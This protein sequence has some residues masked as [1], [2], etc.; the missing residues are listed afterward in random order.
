MITSEAV[1]AVAEPAGQLG[2]PHFARTGVSARVLSLTCLAVIFFA[3][4]F[5]IVNCRRPTWT[6]VY[7]GM[8]ER[9]SYGSTVFGPFNLLSPSFN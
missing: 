5:L 6:V 7:G 4:T 3:S 8:N 9:L 2:P 1:V